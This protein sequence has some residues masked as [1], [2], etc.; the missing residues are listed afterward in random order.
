[1]DQASR[2]V[3]VQQIVDLPMDMLREASLRAGMGPDR[4]A[5]LMHALKEVQTFLG[6]VDIAPMPHRTPVPGGLNTGA[7]MSYSSVLKKFFLKDHNSTLSVGSVSANSAAARQYT[8][9]GELRT[10]CVGDVVILANDNRLRENWYVLLVDLYPPS[11][12]KFLG[13]GVWL[14]TPEDVREW[15]G[16]KT[17]DMESDRE[18]FLSDYEFEV[19]LDTVIGKCH[20]WHQ[21]FD[22][23]AD[24]DLVCT[25]FLDHIGKTTHRLRAPTS[26][27]ELRAVLPLLRRLALIA[28]P[29]SSCGVFV[30]LHYKYVVFPFFC[31]RFARVFRITDCLSL[32]GVSGYTRY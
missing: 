31:V 19:E 15:I 26:R 29:V 17:F 7:P 32:C 14:W 3:A 25:K 12:S 5:E 22:S 20:V 16:D 21:L 18:V 4:A 9:T 30:R 23:G 1:M 24:E 11:T 8:R 13:K 27:K 6:R 2:R 10:F 28:N